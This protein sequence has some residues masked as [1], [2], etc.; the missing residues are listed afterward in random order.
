MTK[1]TIIIVT[2]NEEN[3]IKFCLDSLMAMDYPKKDLCI[4]VSDGGSTDNT[5]N[6]VKEY[7]VR[8]IIK[9]GGGVAECKNIALDMCTEDYVVFI[10]ADVIVSKNWLKQLVGTIEKSEEDIVAVGGPNLVMEG[11]Y[12]IAKIIGYTQELFIGSGGSPQ[13]SPV[14]QEKEVISASNCNALYRCNVLKEN[15]FDE[16]FNIGD[17]LEINFRLRLKGYKFLYAPKAI[18]YHR[19][20][21]NLKKLIAQSIIYSEAM[22]R[23]T[24]KFKK[25]PRWY[26]PIPSIALICFVLFPL[27]YLINKEI[28]HFYTLFIFVYIA[29]ILVSTYQVYKKTHDRKSLFTLLII[30]LQHLSY[31]YGYI[32]GL[33]G[34]VK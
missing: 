18:V 33:I 10:D 1:I 17:D 26:A 31:G 11:D 16:L 34:H 8:L 25:I 22:A 13:S 27:F 28:L 9:E 12:K 3:N 6:T 4:I 5:L 30:P 20:P 15:K 23:V 19:R 7:P 29:A 32:K 24:K 2:L 21:K 14:K